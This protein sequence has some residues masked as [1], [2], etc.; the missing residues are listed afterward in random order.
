MRRKKKPKRIQLEEMANRLDHEIRER[1]QAQELSARK[2]EL[3][4]G[5][6]EVL[7]D[8]LISSS[9]SHVARSSLVVAEKLTQSRFGLVGTINPEG[10]VQG[11]IH[12]PHRLE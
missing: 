6:R 1:S 2:N 4:E 11:S 10:I 5:V 7:T 3:L 9:T 8:T 12:E